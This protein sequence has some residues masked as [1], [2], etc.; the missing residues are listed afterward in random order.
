MTSFIGIIFV[1]SFQDEE[2]K[3]L[4]EQL[5]SDVESKLDRVQF[6]AL[7]EE[8]EKQLRALAKRLSLMSRDYN[9]LDDDAAGIRKWVPRK[10]IVAHVRTNHV[11]TM[12]WLY[13]SGNFWRDS[14]VCRATGRLILRHK[15]K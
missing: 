11:V 12:F 7:K 9:N 15:G 5:H 13:V 14:T 10:N 6:D 8:L 3:R 1:L 4:F 2:W